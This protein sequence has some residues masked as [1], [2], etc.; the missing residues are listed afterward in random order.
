MRFLKA[1]TVLRQW[2]NSISIFIL[3]ALLSFPALAIEPQLVY[4][5]CYLIKSKGI[6]N[7]FVCVTQKLDNAR[8]ITE[9]HIEQRFKRQ[10]DEIE[11]IQDQIFVEDE[12]GRPVE[13]SFSSDDVKVKGEFD[14]TNYEIIVN[15][16]ANG[17]KDVQVIDIREEILFPYEISKLYVKKQC[18][19]FKY[20]TIEPGINS[21]LLRVK[22]EQVHDGKYKLDVNIFPNADVFE[23]R[24][25]K[26]RL[27]KAYISILDIEQVATDKKQ[28]FTVKND[29]NVFNETFIKVD[30]IISQPESVQEAVYKII[31]GNMPV[32]DIFLTDNNQSIMQNY[33]ERA[34]LKV[35]AEKHESLNQPY[36]FDTSGY[37]DYLESGPFIMPEN[38]EIQALANRLKAGE[39]DAV[40]L[41]KKAER[42]VY[43]NIK[44]KNLSIDFASADKILQNLSG[45]C[46]EHSVLLASLLRAMGIPAKAVVGLVYSSKPESAFVYHMWIK[47]YT[48][49]WISLDPSFPY[50]TFTP[51][52]LAMAESSLND[53]SAKTELVIDIIDSVSNIDIE[54]LNTL[55]PAIGN[56][57]GRPALQIDMGIIETEEKE[58]IVNI[59]ISGQDDFKSNIYKI[60]LLE[61]KDPIDPLKSAFYNFTHGNIREAEGDLRGV[62]A[63]IEPEDDYAKMRLA[64]KLINM[65][66]FSFAREVLES[67]NDYEIWGKMIEDLYRVYFPQKG[68]PDELEKI[69]IKAFYLLNYKDQ[70][71]LVLDVTEDIKGYDYVHYLRAKAFK[72]IKSLKEAVD[73]IKKAIELNP[74]NLTYKL[75]Y[76]DLLSAQREIREA[77]MQLSYL[78]LE[79]KKH[80]IKNKEFWKKFN[81]FDYWLKVK[82]FRE[83]IILSK[84]YEAYYYAAKGEYDIATNIVNQLVYN[85]GE[86]Y[87]HEF[88]G[89]LYFE[90]D[91][92][93]S[94]AKAYQEALFYDENRVKS[95]IGLGN[96]F[97]ISGLN[98]KAEKYYLRAIEKFP[99]NIDALLA[100]A[101]LQGYQGNEEKAYEYF[102]KILKLDKNNPDVLYN[103]GIILANKGQYEQARSTLKKALSAG[104]MSSLVWLELAKIE[105]IRKN[106]TK[107]ANYL[108]NI[109]YINDNNPDYYYYMGVILKK[110]NKTAE[111]E[112]FFRKAGE[113]RR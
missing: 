90:Q 29:F 70:F 48:G 94:A 41:A 12:S 46:T 106:Y 63:N 18:A 43:D 31:S 30:K 27:T 99:K 13:F 108:K 61:N 19:S 15:T 60:E 35:R 56:L 93:D 45:D 78:N 37:E 97:F 100:M 40:K 77:Q 42:W 39:T 21:R 16:T 83:N 65:S 33:G 24:D 104:P 80:N 101:K 3:F 59:N 71:D 8:V 51:L 9:K 69:Q 34:Y 88:L 66:Y 26:G 75:Y 103:I 109:N 87:L 74:D 47:A 50:E 57:N 82:E 38:E 68:A 76:I 91:Y 6:E 95:N 44:D 84:Y 92:F 62:Y 58:G 23:W 36:P 96:I 20:T 53:V 5:Q 54:V 111:A 55:T 73:E 110:N 7:G 112:K 72:E 49:K 28:I 1:Y 85:S 107:S 81:S 25:E 22:A 11:I 67:I 17:I 113:L 2:V 89:E 32:S 98:E 10:D 52:H 105:I 79:A 14:W 4:E 102:K 64:L 86:A